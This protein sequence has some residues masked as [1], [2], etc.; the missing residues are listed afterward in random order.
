MIR[1][2]SMNSRKF[3]SVLRGAGAEIGGGGGGG[4]KPGR[5]GKK[6]K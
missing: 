4:G 1:K 5:V 3:K 2:R 6:Y